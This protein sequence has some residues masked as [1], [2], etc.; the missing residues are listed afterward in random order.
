MSKMNTIFKKIQKKTGFTLTEVMVALFLF[1]LTTPAVLR[2]FIFFNRFILDG[3]EQTRNM[4]RARYFEQFFLKKVT[5][6]QRVA[7]RIN[8]SG[9]LVSFNIPNMTSTNTSWSGAS[10]LYRAKSNDVLFATSTGRKKVVLENV[11]PIK[12]GSNRIFF[13]EH[14]K[15]IITCHLQVGGKSKTDNQDVEVCFSVYPRN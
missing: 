1:S 12:K 10:F 4:D 7:F 11:F 14:N 9:T 5:S 15:K 3:I 13:R 8:D 6:T 2:T